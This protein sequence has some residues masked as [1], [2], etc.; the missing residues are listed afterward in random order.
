MNLK[1]K[2]KQTKKKV[3]DAAYL[4]DHSRFIVDCCENRSN[5]SCC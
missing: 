5:I 1:K 4:Y 3:Q 2:N